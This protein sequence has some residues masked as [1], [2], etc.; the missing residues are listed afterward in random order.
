M[1]IV[2]ITYIHATLY[3]ILQLSYEVVVSDYISSRV[4][5]ILIPI[6]LTILS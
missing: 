3:I 5:Y 2:F 6:Y 4:L 1:C